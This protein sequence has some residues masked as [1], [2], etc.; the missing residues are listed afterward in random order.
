MPSHSPAIWITRSAPGCH[1]DARRLKSHNVNAFSLPLTAIQYASDITRVLRLTADDALI[2]TSPHAVR[3]L[4][5]LSA[6]EKARRIVY[7]S[8]IATWRQALSAGFSQAVYTG[9]VGSHITTYLEQHPTHKH[10]IHCSGDRIRSDITASLT[11]GRRIIVYQS[12][13][14]PVSSYYLTLLQTGKIHA[15]CFFSV[16]AAQLWKKHLETHVP[17]AIKRK[18]AY[19]CLSQEIAHVFR[20]DSSRIRIASYPTPAILCRDVLHDL[21]TR[22]NY[23]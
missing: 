8:G 3:A 22:K 13:Y 7:I 19:Y 11:H 9:P 16:Y 5:T 6:E 14:T 10:L 4:S 20:N 18:P 15:V 1:T 12:A 21:R 2:F 17:V 23:L